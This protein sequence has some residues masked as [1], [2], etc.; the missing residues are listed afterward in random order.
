MK[1]FFSMSFRSDLPIG[2]LII[3]YLRDLGHKMVNDSYDKGNDL[4]KVFYE[5]STEKRLVHYK[6]VFQSLRSADIVVLESSIHSLTI[7]QMIQEAIDLR[8]PL[9]V[10]VKKGIKLTFLDGLS[11]EDGRLVKVEYT[12]ETLA[13]K[14]KE[15]IEYLTEK[16]GTRFTLIL[17]PEIIQHL[18]GISKSG[19][20]RS[21]YIRKL[22]SDDIK[23]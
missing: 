18:D 12:P 6:A 23:R 1:V 22:I 15:G 4:P 5:W 14:L 10:L 16:L 11:E 2:Y 7:G 17:P 13:S 9:L 20:S 3:K 21:E 8:K 19:L